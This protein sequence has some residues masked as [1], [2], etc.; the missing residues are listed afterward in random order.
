[1]KDGLGSC[2]GLSE[3]SRADPKKTFQLDAC[4]DCH[5]RIESVSQVHESSVFLCRGCT[6]QELQDQA[7]AALA[8]TAYKF[9][10]NAT[11]QPRPQQP[12]PLRGGGTPANRFRSGSREGAT[13]SDP[14]T[15]RGIHLLEKGLESPCGFWGNR[16]WSI[17]PGCHVAKIKRKFIAVKT[18]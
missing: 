13:G 2:K 9:H 17:N 16:R 1:M 14:A 11:G 3:V 6:G 7:P 5:F 10:Q 8:E 15:E 12:L 18:P 4:L